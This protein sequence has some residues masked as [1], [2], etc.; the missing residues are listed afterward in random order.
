MAIASN[1]PRILIFLAAGFSDFTLLPPERLE[2][3]DGSEP[4]G[5][6]VLYDGAVVVALVSEVVEDIGDD[7]EVLELGAGV[8]SNGALDVDV[9]AAVLDEVVLL[10]TTTRTALFSASMGPCRLFISSDH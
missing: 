1:M 8:V 3:V 9:D 4:D 6:L 5:A 10:Q 7:V 2:G